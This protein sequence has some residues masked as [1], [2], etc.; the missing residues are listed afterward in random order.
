MT[1]YKLITCTRGVSPKVIKT[2]EANSEDEAKALFKPEIEAN[3]RKYNT[4]GTPFV[5]NYKTNKGTNG[6]ANNVT[7]AKTSKTTNGT[8]NGTNGYTVNNNGGSKNNQTDAKIKQQQYDDYMN[9]QAEQNKI[10]YNSGNKKNHRYTDVTNVRQNYTNNKPN[11]TYTITTADGQEV[12]NAKYSQ[13]A[14]SFYVP[15]KKT[16][17]Q[18]NQDDSTATPKEETPAT[19]TPKE[20]TPAADTPSGIIGDV[21]GDGEVNVMDVLRLQKSLSGWDVTIDAKNADINGDGEVNVMDVIRLEK[22]V[23]GL[24]TTSEEAEVTGSKEEQRGEIPTKPVKDA[25]GNTVYTPP[26][27]VEDSSEHTGVKSQESNPDNISKTN[28]NIT[29]TEKVSLDSD[30]ANDFGLNS[31]DLNTLRRNYSK[32]EITIR[33]NKI[34]IITAD[35]RQIPLNNALASARQAEQAEQEEQEE[36]VKEEQEQQ[37]GKTLTEPVPNPNRAKRPEAL[38]E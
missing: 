5:E 23:H 13:Y 25:N 10:I 32:A 8:V 34:H 17:S 14:D 1:E 33:N 36:Q 15:N 24:D 26:I 6:T 3:K 28:K 16:N 9:A 31:D 30:T 38:E 22:M 27:N 11:G 37:Q 21:N 35:G 7:S 29:F 19:T 20:E 12:K 18:A 2:V 4:N